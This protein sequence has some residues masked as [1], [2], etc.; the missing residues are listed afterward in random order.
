MLKRLQS[1]RMFELGDCASI[2]KLRRASK[3]EFD[4]HGMVAS[5]NMLLIR[6]LS[7]F[8]GRQCCQR[9]HQWMRS[10]RRRMSASKQKCRERAAML[11][12]SRQIIALVFCEPPSEALLATAATRG[13]NSSADRYRA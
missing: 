5:I 3:M 12:I 9:P 10:W 13:C 4:V 1:P 7:D 6:S 8:V 2:T 11:P